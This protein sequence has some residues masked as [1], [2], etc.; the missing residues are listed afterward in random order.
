[1][2]SL[3]TKSKILTTQLNKMSWW[4]KLIVILV[5]LYVLKKLLDV[6]NITSAL[7]TLNLM[8]AGNTEQFDDSASQTVL[9]CTMY[10]APW[11]GACKSAKPEWEKFEQEFNNKVIGET[12]IIVTKI[13]CDQYPQ[14]AK[15][16]KIEGYP[17]FKFEKNGKY[18]EYTGGR[19]VN[20]WKKYIENIA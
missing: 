3:S 16:Q 17:T 20:D 2:V 10:Y 18:Y 4:Q 8:P 7:T 11:C 6:F 13:D 15:E 5:G 1:M 19:T 9:N 14:I 12:T